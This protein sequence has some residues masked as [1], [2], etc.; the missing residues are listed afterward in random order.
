MGKPRLRE[1]GGLP[2]ATLLMKNYVH[3]TPRNRAK[4]EVMHALEYLQDLNIPGCVSTD[5]LDSHSIDP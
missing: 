1:Q 4:R 3:M 5:S 2:E